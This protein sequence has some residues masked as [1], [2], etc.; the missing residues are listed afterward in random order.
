[1]QFRVGA[2]QSPKLSLSRD[3]FLQPGVSGFAIFI[4]SALKRE[5]CFFITR[6]LGRR[7][8]GNKCIVYWHQKVVKQV[9]LKGVSGK[10]ALIFYVSQRGEKKIIA[11]LVRCLG[12]E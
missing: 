2:Q 1:M 8:R 10:W 11:I 12:K 5:N 3:D 4:R 6:I 9:I 7:R